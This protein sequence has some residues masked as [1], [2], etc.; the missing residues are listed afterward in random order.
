MQALK[1]QLEAAYEKIR[2]YEELDTIKEVE[3]LRGKIKQLQE[4]I[5]GLKLDVEKARY[6]SDSAGEERLKELGERLTY[7]QNLKEAAQKDRA[8]LRKKVTA[9]QEEL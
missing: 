8:D 6:R 5:R 2:T 3:S 4:I 1:E 9:L 7:F